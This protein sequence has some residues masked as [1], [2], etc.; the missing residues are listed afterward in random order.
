MSQRTN[1]VLGLFRK[2]PEDG[3]K[4]ETVLGGERGLLGMGVST[5]RSK[6]IEAQNPHNETQK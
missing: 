4:T 3:S 5:S 1:I 2:K 6:Y